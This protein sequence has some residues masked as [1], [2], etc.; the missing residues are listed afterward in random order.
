MD[1]W[2][3]QAET[4]SLAVT[5]GLDNAEIARREV[6]KQNAGYQPTLDLAASY[7]EARNGVVGSVAGVDS[8]S[9]MIGLQL[10]WNLYQ[11]G[12]TRSLVRQAVANQEKARFDLDNAR[13]QAA[14][15]ARQAFLGVVSGDARVKAL[16]RWC[17]RARLS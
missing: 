5:I 10:G 12:A 3:K 6:A 11:G 2:V 1:A 7:S 16:N 8:H 14:L 15:D 17:C 4:N 13:R 9:A